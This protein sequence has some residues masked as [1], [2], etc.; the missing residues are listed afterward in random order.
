M[1]VEPI[2]GWQHVYS[3]PRT[4]GGKPCIGSRLPVST[5]L[6]ELAD[7]YSVADLVRHHGYAEEIVIEAIKFAAFVLGSEESARL[8]AEDDA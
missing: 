8:G 3:D 5:I 7:G 4:C 1:K 6:E 2:Q